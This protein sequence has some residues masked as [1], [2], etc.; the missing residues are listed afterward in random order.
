M[1]KQLHESIQDNCM[2][3]TDRASSWKPNTCSI[4]QIYLQAMQASPESKISSLRWCRKT[5][6]DHKLPCSEFRFA[7]SQCLSFPKSLPDKPSPIGIILYWVPIKIQS[8]IGY[9]HILLA[10]TV[11]LGPKDCKQPA[12]WQQ[13]KRVEMSVT[14]IN[15]NISCRNR[16]SLLA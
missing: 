13:R 16:G 7:R 8:Q 11:G 5:V 10:C 3:L 1:D 14:E 4:S 6:T 9:H 15:A 2:M 12:V